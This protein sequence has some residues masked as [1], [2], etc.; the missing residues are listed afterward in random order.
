M[1]TVIVVFGSTTGN[2]ETLANSVEEGLKEGLVDVTVKNVTQTDVEELGSYD[3]IIL[4]SSTWGLGELQDD[5]V[6]FYEKLAKVTLPGKKAAVFGPGDEESF[7]DNFCAAVDM[8][9]ERLTECG[10]AMVAAKLKIQTDTG[11]GVDE[12]AEEKVKAWALA[13]AKSL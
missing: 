3:S 2:T 5:F 6:P 10:A 11:S 9:A 1:A 12:L 8:L 7:P 13:I 4:G